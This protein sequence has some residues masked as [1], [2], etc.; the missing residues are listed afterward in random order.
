MPWLTD[1]GFPE[2]GAHGSFVCTSLRCVSTDSYCPQS[3]TAIG[4]WLSNLPIL[5]LLPISLAVS[6]QPHPDHSDSAW[7]LLRAPAPW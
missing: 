4:H 6:H 2:L 5:D 1:P 3:G 7:V